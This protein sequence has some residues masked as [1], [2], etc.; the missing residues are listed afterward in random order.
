MYTSNDSPIT[1]TAWAVVEYNGVKYYQPDDWQGED[2]VHI[3]NQ[4]GQWNDQGCE[5]ELNYICETNLDGTCGTCFEEN[6]LYLEA[7]IKNVNSVLECF[8]LCNLIPAC[9]VKI[10]VF[11]WPILISAHLLFI[12]TSCSLITHFSDH[13]MELLCFHQAGKNFQ[14]SSKQAGS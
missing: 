7:D 13:V 2:C 10:D 11:I 3:I 4:Q 14:G 9:Q 12:S 8:E 5:T 1:Y 6:I